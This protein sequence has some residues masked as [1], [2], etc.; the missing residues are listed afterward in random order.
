MGIK[1]TATRT[2]YGAP[3]TFTALRPSSMEVGSG[4]Y[5]IS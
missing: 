5:S 1:N 3:F 4:G 2:N